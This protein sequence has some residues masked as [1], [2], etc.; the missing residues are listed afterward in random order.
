MHLFLCALYQKLEN[1]APLSYTF[2]LG[3]L[4]L[5]PKLSTWAKTL[6]LKS[7]TYRKVGSNAQYGWKS[8][9]TGRRYIFQLLHLLSYQISSNQSINICFPSL[10]VLFLQITVTPP[11][12]STERFGV[13]KRSQSVGS[14]SVSLQQN[15]AQ[16]SVASLQ[17]F[18]PILAEYGGSYHF[19][20]DRSTAIHSNW[21]NG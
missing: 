20:S 18:F 14:T 7:V 13:W 17:G 11:W 21:V 5:P 3:W 1:Y 9:I 4:V 8:N 12:I 19:P 16:T 15:R 2:V 6:V 10:F